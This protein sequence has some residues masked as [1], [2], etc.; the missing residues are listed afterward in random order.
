MAIDIPANTIGYAP[1]SK[2]TGLVMTDYGF[3]LALGLALLAAVDPFELD[4]ERIVY[5][6]HLPMLFAA[7]SLILALAGGRIFRWREKR[8]GS[9]PAMMP[10]LMFAAMVLVGGFYARVQLNIQNSFLIAG[11]YVLAAPMAA[12]IL[13]RCTEPAR[14]LQAYFV[15]LLTG[16]AVVFTGLAINYGV[17]QVYHELEYLFPALAVLIAFLVK[18]RWLR[19]TGILFFLLL[20]ALFKKNTGYLTGVLVAGYLLVFYAWPQW[21]RHDVVRKMTTLHWLLVG[22]LL[23]GM[24]AAFLIANRTHYLPSGSPAYRVVTYERAW[25][26][27]LDSPIWGTGFTGAGAEKFTAFETGVSDNVLPTHSD[28]LD[29]FAHGGVLGAALWLWGLWRVAR[30]AWS[31]VLRPRYRAHRLAPYGHALVCMSVAGVLTYAFN[32]IILQPAKSL[33]LWANLGFLVGISLMIKQEG[34]KNASGDAS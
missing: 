11:V 14:L 24:L 27:F 30:L 22:I 31:T 8:P 16:G 19:W 23:F 26:R 28:I 33:L 21:A 9:L 32:P 25:Q 2:R 29:I 4:L 17:R 15:M 18:R 1:G 34:L 12:A 6:K 13:L 3:L 10:L 7:S 20:A 5:T